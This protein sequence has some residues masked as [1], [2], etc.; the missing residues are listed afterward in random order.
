M[1]SRCPHTTKFDGE[2]VSNVKAWY[3]SLSSILMKQVEEDREAPHGSPYIKLAKVWDQAD[4]E[5]EKVDKKIK[6]REGCHLGMWKFVPTTCMHLDGH[7]CPQFTWPTPL[8]M[9]NCGCRRGA[10]MRRGHGGPSIV[11]GGCSWQVLRA[12][13]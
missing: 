5:F 7:V 4:H 2:H 9:P 1:S 12:P 3:K 8:G 13:Q 11:G 6:V 10:W